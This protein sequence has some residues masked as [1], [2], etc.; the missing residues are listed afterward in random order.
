[1]KTTVIAGC[2]SVLNQVVASARRAYVDRPSPV[3][4]ASTTPEAL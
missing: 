4:P 1:M 2:I 3:F